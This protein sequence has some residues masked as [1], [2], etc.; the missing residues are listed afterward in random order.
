MSDAPIPT[1]K[2]LTAAALRADNA[3][4]EQRIGLLTNAI[5]QRHAERTNSLVGLARG[6]AG[7]RGAAL[8]QITSIQPLYRS[9]Q[10]FPISVDFNLLNFMYCT[11]GILQ[12]MV[13]EPVMDAFSGD[14]GPGFEL[15]SREMGEGSVGKDG[16]GEL[17]DFAEETGAWESLKYMLAWGS[18]YGGAGLVINAGQDPEKP[19]DPKDVTRGR[20]EFYDADRWEFSGAYRSAP[21][22]LFY[23]HT[24]DASRV[25]TYGGK[26]APRLERVTLGGWGM[27]ELQRAIEDFNVWLRGRNALYETINKANID[28]YGI[29][30]Y[31]DTLALPN[32]EQTMITRIQA[33]NEIL[34]FS[35]A[36]VMDSEDDY[37]VVSKQFA[38]LAEVMREN[39]IGISCATRM[40]Y[41][42][43]WGTGAGSGGLSESAEVEMKQYHA[44]VTSRVRTPARSIIRKMLRLM[45]YSVFGNE[46]DVSF[47]FRPL[48]A[49]SAPQAEEIKTSK[50]TR[51]IQLWNAKMLT[52]QEMG[53]LLH[54]EDLVPI[55]TALQ[56]GELVPEAGIVPTV[57]EMFK[58]P[59]GGEDAPGK[60]DEHQTGDGKRP[61]AEPAA[62]EPE[63]HPEG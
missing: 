22:F 24:L 39:R 55:E 35:R 7:S 15:T 31:A 44:L 26:R 3:A 25:I 1:S 19:L 28:V 42:K 62:G 23:G 63:P 13:D 32:G 53:D 50:Q 21:T 46:Y 4:L 57:D 54:K 52:P 10:Y 8:D 61:R 18:L 41:V 47:K 9:T 37:K 59:E 29:K 14:D 16:L 12:T 27:S 51:Y 56:R 45:M 20:L 5:Q 11:H 43:L 48:E 17:M 40:P 6:L 30:G 36:L 33:T 49:L 58:Q 2:L 38:G 60:T 34:N